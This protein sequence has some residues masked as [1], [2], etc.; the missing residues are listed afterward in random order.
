MITAPAEAIRF[1]KLAMALQIATFPYED[2][3]GSPS[4]RNFNVTN[5]SRIGPLPNR[6]DCAIQ[7]F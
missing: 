5:L 2:H 7:L 6:L 1:P 4:T 3:A